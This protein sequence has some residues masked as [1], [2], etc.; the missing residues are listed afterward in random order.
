MKKKAVTGFL[1]LLLVLPS[2]SIASAH[3]G[4]TD[5]NGGHTC[6]TNCSK[7]GLDYGEYH[8]HNGGSSSSGSSSSSSSPSSSYSTPKSST[9]K[10]AAPTYKASGLKV[11]VNGQ[12]LVFSSKPVV[13]KNTNLVPLREI[14]EALGA[15]VTY[16][17]DSGTIGVKK[18]NRKVTLTIGSKTVFYNGTSETSSAAP[19]VIKGVTYVPAQVFARGLGAG[20][21]FNSSTNSLKIKL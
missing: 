5:S 19:I 14:A 17:K 3:P 18:G 12:Q 6:W 1:A 13:Y 2:A 4:R 10:P 16:D 11:Y 21:E 7:W 9:P 15:S 20:I 8:Y